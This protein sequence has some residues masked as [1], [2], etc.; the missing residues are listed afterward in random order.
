MS[1]ELSETK[2]KSRNLSE[3]R[4]RDSFNVIVSEL[5]AAVVPA[6]RKLDKS[7]VLKH[8]ITFLR[9]HNENISSTDQD[10]HKPSAGKEHLSNDEI[11][12]YLQRTINAYL[13][14]I[15]SSGGIVYASGDF[16][17]NFKCSEVWFALK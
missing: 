10:L 5:A 9:K 7:N 8:T 17:E 14:V 16:I 15:S 2:R 4:R 1:E 11:C 3:K 13:L 6:D 12:T